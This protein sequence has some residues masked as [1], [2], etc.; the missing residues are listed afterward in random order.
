MADVTFR[1]G[2]QSE[3]AAV[4]IVDGQLLWE[5]TNNIIYMDSGSTRLV[6]AVGGSNGIRPVEYGGTGCTSAGDIGSTLKLV[7]LAPSTFTIPQGA[8]V[9]SYITPGVYCCPSADIAATLSNCP[10][11]TGAFVL[12]VRAVADTTTVTQT[13]EGCSLTSNCLVYH[14]AYIDGSFGEWIEGG[15]GGVADASELTG[16]LNTSTLPIVPISKGGTGATS[17][18]NALSALGIHI[19]NVD[20]GS[21]VAGDIYIITGGN[22]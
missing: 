22:G 15:G 10:F 4:P 7:T 18:S 9:N 12:T 11:T 1:R 19:C 21:Y 6:M 14:R 5:T 20:P 17:K 2:T 16:T 13:I 8:N 3:I